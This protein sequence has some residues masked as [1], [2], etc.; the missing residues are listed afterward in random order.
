MAEMEEIRKVKDKHGAKIMAKKNV[1]GMGV[2]YK[3]TK[4]AMRSVLAPFES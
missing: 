3:E 2:G 4:G 1:V